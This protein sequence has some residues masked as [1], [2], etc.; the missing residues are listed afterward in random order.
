MPTKERGVV[1]T[2][3]REGRGVWEAA[4]LQLDCNLANLAF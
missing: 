2:V 1:I 3:A 4:E